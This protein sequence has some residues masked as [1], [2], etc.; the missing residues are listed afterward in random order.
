[1]GE[2]QSNRQWI[3]CSEMAGV[4]SP[5]VISPA[6]ASPGPAAAHST[7]AASASN[8]TDAAKAAGRK[9]AKATEKKR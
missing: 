1:M 7:K 5:T 4:E 3:G 9:T 6:S 2:M 8:P